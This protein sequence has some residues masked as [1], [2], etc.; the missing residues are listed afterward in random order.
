LLLLAIANFIIQGFVVPFLRGKISYELDDLK[1]DVEDLSKEKDIDYHQIELA[2]SV[3][4]V[5]I[6]MIPIDKNRLA[7]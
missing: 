6:D 5:T 2:D 1:E 3:I 4:D 7:Y